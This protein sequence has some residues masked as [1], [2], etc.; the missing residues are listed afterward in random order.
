MDEQYYYVYSLRQ[1]R[2]RHAP[3]C[4]DTRFTPNNGANQ[5]GRNKQQNAE[6]GAMIATK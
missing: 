2:S 4:H 3:G 5:P 6:T 1:Q